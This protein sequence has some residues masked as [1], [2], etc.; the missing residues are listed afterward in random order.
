MI[1]M[2]IC[3]S[4]VTGCNNCS[5]IY[6]ELNSQFSGI[7]HIQHPDCVSVT[8]EVI[9]GINNLKIQHT[10]GVT[11]SSFVNMGKIV[12][13]VRHLCMKSSSNKAIITKCESVIISVLLLMTFYLSNNHHGLYLIVILFSLSTVF[14]V[15]LDCAKPHLHVKVPFENINKICLNKNTCSPIKCKLSYTSTKYSDIPATNKAFFKDSNC[16]IR[17]P[18]HWNNWMKQYFPSADSYYDDTDNDGLSNIVEYYGKTNFNNTLENPVTYRGMR[19]LIYYYAIGTSPTNSDSDEDFLTDGFEYRYQLNAKEK[20]DYKADYDKDG[21]SNLQEQILDTDPKNP[22]TDGDGVLDGTEVKNKAD[23]KDPTDGGKEDT[24]IQTALIRLTIG[25]GNQNASPT[26]R[27]VLNVGDISHQSSNF[28]KTGTGTYRFK[29]GTYEISVQHVWS[30][31]PDPNHSYTALVQKVG[32]DAMAKVF[33]DFELLGVHDQI[34]IDY[35]IG[36]NASLVIT[37]N[38]SNRKTEIKSVCTCLTTCTSC[39]ARSN[40]IWQKTYCRKIRP[41]DITLQYCE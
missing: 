38:C 17:I 34:R 21:L 5:W 33:D 3:I 19:E 28:G 39:T 25:I 9:P 16:T 6:F 18:K 35:T 41:Y 31:L 27:Y 11:V 12:L 4:C 30:K 10:S 15:P 14:P 26:E 36:K 2:G 29:P 40:C 20:D 7:I 32:G 13:K 1:L 8:W 24:S 37:T 22:D 23:P